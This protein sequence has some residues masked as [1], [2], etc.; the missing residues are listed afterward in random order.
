MQKMVHEKKVL[1]PACQLYKLQA[2]YL[3]ATRRT[4]ITLQGIFWP[5]AV[6]IGG[7]PFEF[8]SS[9]Q[10]QRFK[11]IIECTKNQSV[12]AFSLIAVDNFVASSSFFNRNRYVRAT[13]VPPA[14]SLDCES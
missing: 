11:M 3:G 14:D 6:A 5:A 7:V 9:C 1:V 10:K 4:K 2:R 13:T 12:G 8:Y